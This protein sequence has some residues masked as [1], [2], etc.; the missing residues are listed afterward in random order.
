MRPHISQLDRDALNDLGLVESDGCA[1]GLQDFDDEA[2][3]PIVRVGNHTNPAAKVLQIPAAKA[4]I[5][6]GRCSSRWNG[7]ETSHCAACHQTFTGETAFNKHRAGSHGRGTRH[8]V[9]P[10]SVGL[11]DAGRAYL[12]WGLPGRA[13]EDSMPS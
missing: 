4:A 3:T 9:E 7:L 6:C 13:N 5:G 11:V 8:C 12:C 2:V 10:V 1:D